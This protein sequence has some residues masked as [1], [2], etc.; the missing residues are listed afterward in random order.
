MF[1]IK[2][3]HFEALKTACFQA[4][5]DHPFD[6][7]EYRAAGLSAKR[8]RWDVYNRATINGE[9][10]Y[11]FTCDTL[12]PYLDDTHIDSALRAILPIF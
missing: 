1:K 3:E 9:P 2:P 7:S 10:S 12:Y 8:Y 11:R 5:K 6:A 4:L